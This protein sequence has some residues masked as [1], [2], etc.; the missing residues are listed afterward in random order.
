M[1]KSNIVPSLLSI[2]YKN[3]YRKIEEISKKII[4]S[5]SH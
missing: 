2:D 4:Q 3:L 5:L 1:E